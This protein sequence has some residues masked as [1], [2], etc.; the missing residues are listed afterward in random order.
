MALTIASTEDLEIM[1]PSYGGITIDGGGTLELIDVEDTSLGLEN[2]TLADGSSEGGGA[3]FA[4]D[5]EIGIFNCT[6]TNNGAAEGGAILIGF[7]IADIVN[8][9]FTGNSAFAGGAVFV[10]EAEVGITNCTFSGNSAEDGAD[11]VTEPSGSGVNNSI[12]ANSISGGNCDGVGDDGYNISDDDSCG[13]SGTSVN[14]STTLNLDPLGL[15][16]NGGPTQTIALESG[17]QAIDFVPIASCV[18]AFDNPVTD[19]QRLFTRPD[20]GENVCDVG[21]YESG[22]VAPIVLAPKSERVQIARSGSANSDM[23]N[24][25]F[26]FTING[27]PDCD[28]DEDALNSGIN[29]SLFGSTCADIPA[30]GLELS[31]SPFVVSTV[32]HQSYGTLFQSFPPEDSLGPDVCA[33]NSGRVVRGMDAEPRGG[34]PRYLGPGTWRQQSVRPGIDGYRRRPGRMLRHHECDRR[35]SDSDART[36]CAARSEALGATT[37]R[38]IYPNCYQRYTV[39]RKIAGEVS[40]TSR[41]L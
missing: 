22:A 12:F 33:P 39:L 26:T 3:L 27:D 8:C 17:S 31:L 9:T 11:I 5:S 16:N 40:M 4:D 34:W 20:D 30:N 24:M 41:L 28:A 38:F 21:A 7:S 25:A 14:N 36:P 35:Q 23:V 15:Q 13:F 10:V 29:V 32:N 19:D 18:D 1:G 6:F 2:L 37:A